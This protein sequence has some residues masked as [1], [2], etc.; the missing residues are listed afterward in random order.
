MERLSFWGSGRS[1][2]AQKPFKKVGGL[3]PYLFKG[4]LGPLTSLW[5]CFAVLLLSFAMP[6]C[7]NVSGRRG[8]P[9]LGPKRGGAT[10]VAALWVLKKISKFV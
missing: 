2:A 3:A 9:P 8:G 7:G 10:T 1:R 6:C 5:L 4:F